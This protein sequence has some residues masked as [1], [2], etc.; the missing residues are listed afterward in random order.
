VPGSVFV[1]RLGRKAQRERAHEIV[2]QPAIGGGTR[3]AATL[4]EGSFG[5]RGSSSGRMSLLSTR[6]ALARTDTAR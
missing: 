3:S 2:N 5:V 1:E 4:C 6:V